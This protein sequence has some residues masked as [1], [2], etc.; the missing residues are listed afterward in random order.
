MSQPPPA[1][2]IETERTFLR[3]H[4]LDDFDDY[5]ALWADPVVTR[6]IGGR[7]RSR[8]ESWIRILRYAGMWQFIGYGMWVV[9]DKATGRLIGEAGFHELRRD[10]VPVFEGSPEAGWAFVPD[11]HGKGI[12]TEVVR[13]FHDWAND[14]P[15]FE[16]T[17]CIIDPAHA[18]SLAVA[19]KLGYREKA[20]AIYHDEPVILL[21]RC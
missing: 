9:E 6:F 15:G 7:P 12:A 17:V 21:E 11:M 14:R 18:V 8:E 5:A 2:V 19:A 3:A 4:R 1:P 20:I 13:A 16:R 10:V